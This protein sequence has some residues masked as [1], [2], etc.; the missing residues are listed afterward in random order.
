MTEFTKLEPR[1][2]PESI[3]LVMGSHGPSIWWPS[4]EMP[5]SWKE[6][7]HGVR[8]VREDLLPASAK[9]EV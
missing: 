2:A 7:H 3:T 8:Y 1:E 6:D 9:V 4:A 5:A